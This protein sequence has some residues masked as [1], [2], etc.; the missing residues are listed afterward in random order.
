MIAV[1]SVAGCGEPPPAGGAVD[2][3]AG[4]GDVAPTPAEF[5][6]VEVSGTTCANGTPAGLGVSP[7][8]G[9]DE[10]VVLIAGGG[11]CW[12]DWT[13]FGLNAAVNLS[14]TYG[15]QVMAAELAPIIASG[16]V[17]RGDPASRAGAANLAYLPYCTGD[18]HA[19]TVVRR[20]QTDV[21]GT[22]RDV[23]H[24]GRLNMAALAPALA[25]RFPDVS[26]VYL[27]GLSAG[28]YGAML[29]YDLFAAAF[30]AAE[31]HLLADGSAW[32]PTPQGEWATWQARW[33]AA[34]PAGCADCATR[35]EAIIAHLRTAAPTRRFG[36]ITTTNDEVIRAFFGYGVFGDITAQVGALVDRQY[37]AASANAHA[38]VEAGT[39]HVLLGG[40]R[41]RTGPG[42][43][44]LKQFV[45]GWFDGDAGFATVRP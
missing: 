22:M 6:Y 4:D 44:P 32:L 24:V 17:D 34:L 29:D 36:L 18:L 21:A 5:T 9:A 2:A 31:V 23:H 39:Q 7:Q 42:G 3:G 13:C 41:T 15:A 30:P 19:G 12:D 20:Y 43:V 45:D 35:P 14:T 10:L 11:A 40:Y 1:V 38:Y 37:P 25:V 27:V 28:G 8:A 33:Q 16:L 26:R